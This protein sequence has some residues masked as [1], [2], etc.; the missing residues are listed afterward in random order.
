MAALLTALV[1]VGRLFFDWKRSKKNTTKA[2]RQEPIENA[3]QA[4]TIVLNSLDALR[5]ENQGLRRKIERLEN[6]N[7]ELRRRDAE[8]RETIQELQEQLSK[9]QDQLNKAQR[10]LDELSKE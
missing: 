6:D 2:K 3:S 9:L 4:N 8:S 10:Q 7:E 5:E 1:N